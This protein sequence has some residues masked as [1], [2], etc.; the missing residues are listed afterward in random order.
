[1]ANNNKQDGEGER[2]RQSSWSF[3]VLSKEEGEELGVL[4]ASRTCF[5][6]EELH[7][8]TFKSIRA[9]GTDAA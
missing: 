5:G 7:L 2:L 3:L 8:S 1:M 4:L 9:A 6:D